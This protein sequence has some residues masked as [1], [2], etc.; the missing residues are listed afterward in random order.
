M[1]SDTEKNAESLFFLELNDWILRQSAARW[2]APTGIG[3]LL[4]NEAYLTLLLKYLDFIAKGLRAIRYLGLRGC[5]LIFMR[6]NCLWGW[7]DPRNT[8]TLPLWLE[9]FPNA[10]IICVER[11]G[12][13]V[14]KSLL[15][16][17]KHDITKLNDK[18]NIFKWLYSIRLKKEALGGSCLINSETDAVELWKQYVEEARRHVIQYRA[19]SLFI[20]YEE[21]LTEPEAGIRRLAE[22]V[23][24]KVSENEVQRIVLMVDKSRANAS[25]GDNDYR[26]FYSRH[27]NILSIHNADPR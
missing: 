12:V 16:R 2:D 5:W 24:A 7:K 11:N 17:Q 14:A 18:F 4:K 6:P 19:N 1:G 22:F 23:G 9:L 25:S 13:D 26:E 21:F 3:N 8:F 20:N 10:K 27:E 15:S